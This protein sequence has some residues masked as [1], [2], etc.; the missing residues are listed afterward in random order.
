MATFFSLIPQLLVHLSGRTLRQ[1]FPELPLPHQHHQEPNLK[2]FPNSQ[3]Y[4]SVFISVKYPAGIFLPLDA[5]FLPP[6]IRYSEAFSVQHP[7]F[8]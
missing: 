1:M 3:R 4:S 8:N 6:Q 5:G 7:H 2:K